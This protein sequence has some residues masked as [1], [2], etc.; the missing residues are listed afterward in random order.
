[1]IKKAD[2]ILLI[3]LIVLGGIITFLSFNG[4]AQGRLAIVTVDGEIYGY[5]PLDEDREIKIEN[6]SNTN[7]ITIKD[8]CIQMTSSTCKNQICVHQGKI[9]MTRDKIVCLPNK[10]II[11]ITDKFKREGDIDVIS[12]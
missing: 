11:E 4:N 1:M 8:K 10:I 12:G 7:Y 9:S 5:Y 3:V 2:I 6:G